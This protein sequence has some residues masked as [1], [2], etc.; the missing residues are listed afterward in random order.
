[1]AFPT[2][3]VRCGLR[4]T[5]SQDCHCSTCCGHFASVEAFDAHFPHAHEGRCQP[6]GV[7]E[8]A[9]FWR[10]PWRKWCLVLDRASKPAKWRRAK[11]TERAA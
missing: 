8:R 7:H 10:P 4:W 6:M 11:P 1:M 5:S 9:G 3:C 2:S